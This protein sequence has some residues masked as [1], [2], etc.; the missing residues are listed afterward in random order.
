MQRRRAAVYK[1]VSYKSTTVIKRTEDAKVAT[2]G[3][4]VDTAGR[5]QCDDEDTHNLPATVAKLVS[6][7]LPLAPITMVRIIT[8]Q[9]LRLYKLGQRFL[10]R[11]DNPIGAIVD[12]NR[13]IIH[14][15]I[16]TGH[17]ATVL[18]SHSAGKHTAEHMVYDCI[19]SLRVAPALSTCLHLRHTAFL[20]SQM[21]HARTAVPRH[22]QSLWLMWA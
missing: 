7:S 6:E 22:Q 9:D 14:G 8:R 12:L 17:L 21:R 16:H 18:T 13:Q 2:D 3:H 11:L 10:D 19:H 20:P 15:V 1:C 5:Q 4:A